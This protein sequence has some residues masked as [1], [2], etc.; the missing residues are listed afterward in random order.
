MYGWR[1]ILFTHIIR[2][3]RRLK[4][5]SVKY[6]PIS[7][8]IGRHVL[9]QTLNKTIYKCPLHLHLEWSE[10]SGG[11][12]PT[13]TG[14]T[15]HIRASQRAEMGDLARIFSEKL[16]PTPF[17]AKPETEILRTPR[18]WTPRHRLPI[19]LCIHYGVY[20]DAKWHFVFGTLTIGPL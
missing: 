15:R 18:Q 2:P 9:E 12:P 5:V 10:S 7:I 16:S 17:P 1:Q 11:V 6:K 4:N 8:K 19:R 20:L 13:V 3:I 14:P